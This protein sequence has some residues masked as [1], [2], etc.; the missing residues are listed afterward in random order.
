M[1][2]KLPPAYKSFYEREKLITIFG[3]DKTSFVAGYEQALIDSAAPELLAALE[4]VAGLLQPHHKK[5]HDDTPL[6]EVNGHPLTY[7]HLRHINRLIAKAK[8]EA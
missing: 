5:E 2:E 4:V 1:N 3:L 6:F 8:G 7:G